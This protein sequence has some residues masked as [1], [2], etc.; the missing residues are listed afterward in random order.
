MRILII[1]DS[2][3]MRRIIMNSL[4]RIGYTDI[5]QAGD[6]KEGLAKVEQGNIDIIFTDWNMPIMNGLEFV[7]ALRASAYKATPLLMIT[8]NAAKEDIIEALKA[9][10]DNYVVKPFTPEVLREKLETLLKKYDKG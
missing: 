6:G 1:D 9:G 5:E 4:S 3:T 2:S 10:V 7:L 8:T